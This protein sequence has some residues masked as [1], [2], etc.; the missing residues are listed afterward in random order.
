MESML[1]SDFQR[2]PDHAILADSIGY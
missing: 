2:T 1:L